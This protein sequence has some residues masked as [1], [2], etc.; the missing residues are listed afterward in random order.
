MR[1]SLLWSCLTLTI[2]GH[3]E[4]FYYNNIAL[5]VKNIAG[6]ETWKGPTSY[7]ASILREWKQRWET[8]EEENFNN[9][10]SELTRIIDTILVYL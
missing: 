3:T 7:S 5:N 8:L 6:K 10:A 9:T 1:L 2:E 4:H